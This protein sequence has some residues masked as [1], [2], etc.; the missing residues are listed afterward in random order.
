VRYDFTKQMAGKRA[1][2]ILPEEL[3]SEIDN[4]VGSRGRTRFIVTAATDEVRRRRQFQALEEAAGSWK[5]T[6]HPELKTGVVKWV[7][8]VR[9]ESERRASRN[10][11]RD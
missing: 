1:H 7:K 10:P 5:D 6:D 3:L 11:P 8:K 4:L 2:I 9:K